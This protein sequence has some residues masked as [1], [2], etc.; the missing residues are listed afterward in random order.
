MKFLITLFLITFTSFQNS[1]AQNVHTIDSLNTLL[2]T[3][4]ED[5]NK[6]N[7]L[8]AI[9]NE[10]ENTKPD[11]AV[12]LYSR[13]LEIARKINDGL[14]IANCYEYLGLVNMNS[15]SKYVQAEIFFI[16][17]KNIRR[18]ILGEKHLKYAS[19]LNNLALLYWDMG[20]YA[21]A[22]PLYMEARKI[23]KEKLGK[24]HPVYATNL[25]NLAGLYTKMGQYAKAE[26]LFIEAKNIF[27]EILG[28]KHPE[29]ASSI[30]NLAVLYMKMGQFAKAELL[31]IEVNNICKETLGVK[32]PNY[33][34]S[35]NNLAHLYLNMG[36]YAK[37]E[38]LFIEALKICK[39]TLGVKHPNYA[40]FLNNLAYL[41]SEMGQYAKAEPLYVEAKNNRKEV[42][43]N[44]HPDYAESLNNLAKLYDNLNQ[45]AKAKP[46][47]IESKNIFKEVLG[48]K[49]PNYAQLLNNLAYL[50]LNMGQY[51]KAEPLF[52]EAK[53]IQKEVLG[54][55]HPNY[56]LSLSN[57][58]TLYFK[59][60][61]Y[62][63]AELLY[64]EAKNA[65]K[66]VLGVQHP[67]Y[68]Q[69]LCNLAGL[70]MA[71]H[72]YDKAEPLFIED[73]N[74][75]FANIQSNFSFLSEKEKEEYM[76]T[77]S[78]DFNDFISFAL[79][80]CKE[81]PSITQMAYNSQ[82]A[83]KGLL[84]QSSNKIRDIINNGNDTA[85]IHQYD[86]WLALK[87]DIGRYTQWSKSKLKKMEVNLDSLE[88]LA[89]TVEKE[90]SKKSNVFAED[91]KLLQYTCED[92]K[93]N[94]GEK[95]AAIEFLT[96]KTEKKDYDTAGNKINIPN[97]TYYCALLLRK[98]DKYPQLLKLTNN[99]ELNSILTKTEL[100]QTTAQVKG[101]KP[102]I[103]SYVDD[104]TE[105]QIL[106]KLI[107]KPL[108]TLLAGKEKIYVSL[109]G[110]LNKISYDALQDD[111]KQL[112]LNKY[113]IHFVNSTK[114][115]AITQPTNVENNNTIALFGGITYDIDTTQIKSKAIKSTDI[116]A[117]RALSSDT[118]QGNKWNYLSG[119]L[120]EVNNINKV[121]TK[122]KWNTKLYTSGKATEEAFKLLI[123]KNSPGIIHISTHG[124]F[125]PEPDSTTYS[126]TRN[127]FKTALNPLWRSGIILAGANY[128]WQCKPQLDSV[129][130]GVLTA[131]EVANCNLRNTDL[132]VLS[133]CETGL[134][135]IKTGEGVYGLQRAFQ[136]AGAK[137]VIM[138]L[139]QVPDKETTELMTMFYENYIKTKNKHDS[140]RKAQQVMAK[141]YAPYYWAAF[142]MME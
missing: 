125:F 31:Y 73:L 62:K 141:K 109:T 38:P 88:T 50:Y 99:Y 6:V 74:I 96:Y 81:N 30:N 49:H 61:Q 48:V 110:L 20:Q 63:K 115:L 106:Y 44:K 116:Y 41:Y 124:F 40:Q 80:R 21:K 122:K 129:E 11:T 60:G 103:N 93:K 7:I 12:I 34:L 91:R 52:I 95:D 104:E 42:M 58:A 121:F 67:K 130:D 90:L 82:L 117:S 78:H 114:Q 29:Y 43:G 100:Y 138:S 71:M 22:E 85:L 86:E 9:G 65:R 1:K 46:L 87:E 98:E 105:S 26:P 13:A 68:A 102:I 137:A 77:F 59:M 72:E 120:T 54:E 23:N 97:T 45:Y 19:S 101:I 18:L 4:K 134:G 69:T 64:I 17:S 113:D 142:V 123:G 28:E 79:V 2:K 66:E 53:N 132:V 139:W 75:R 76:K 55:K 3:A 27:N 8:I 35:L 32:H 24:K 128:T 56:A 14:I 83:M 133:A 84:L 127:V 89:N 51:E 136:V 108:D 112:L 118:L 140:F 39:E 5:T 16:N 92:V 37:A 57:L 15:L 111:K 33:A 119:T 10:L 126:T 131:Y 70:Y 94:L 135:D 47:Y 36:Q 107:W 25:N